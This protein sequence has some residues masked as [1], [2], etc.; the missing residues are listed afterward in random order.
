MAFRFEPERDEFKGFF[1]SN[2]A[3]RWVVAA[4]NWLSRRCGRATQ[5]M[6]QDTQSTDETKLM[7]FQR[8]PAPEGRL[9]GPK[10][11]GWLRPASGVQANSS[12]KT[13]CN[14]LTGIFPALSAPG[15]R[16]TGTISMNC[17]FI[18]RTEK[19]PREASP[20]PVTRTT[21]AATQPIR[22]QHVWLP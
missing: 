3:R 15:K 21:V 7:R 22:I 8:H 10:R 5:A 9:A 14:R 2:N 4:W 20:L 11:Q 19:C 6:T 13:V 1:R 17:A 16:R 18:G 12:D